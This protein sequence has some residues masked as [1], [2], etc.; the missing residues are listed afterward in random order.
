MADRDP[1]PIM[2]APAVD[3]LLRRA[4][5][6]MNDLGNARRMAVLADGRLLFVP[7]IGR[8]GEWVWFDGRR[9]S[10]RDGKA[11]SR[12]MAQLVVD[13]L[14]GEAK[15]LRTAAA[16]EIA[17][18][19]G[20][21]F[22]ADMADERAVQLFAW[23]MKTGN[24]DRTSGMIR[25]AEGL[26]DEAGAFLMRSSLDAFDTDPLAWHC[27]NG[28][29]RFVERPE[30]W[31]WRFDEGHDPADRF[32]QMANVEYD[33]LADC[34]AWRA[35]IDLLH[36]DPA[37]RT[38]IQRIYGMTLTALTSDQAFYV[39]QGKGG[40]GKSM[41]NSV[42]A[43]LQGDYFRSTSPQ[44]FLEGKQRNASDHQSDIVRLRG[45]I[46]LVVCDEPPKRAT[47]NGERIKQ[48]TGSLITARAPNA[49]EEITFRP[50]WK[51]IVECNTLPRAPSDDRGFRRRFKLYPWTVQFGVSPGADDRPEHIV[52]QELLAEK[53]GILNWMVAGAIE[54]LNAQAIPEPELSRR[55]LSSFW[56]S[57][58]AM[59]E[60]LETRC[61][62]SN[63]DASAGATELYQDFRQFCLDRGDK[64]ESIANQTVF[65]RALTEAQIYVDKDGA[66]RKVRLG[67][68]LRGMGE[69]VLP[70]ASAATP[71]VPSSQA[72][73]APIEAYDDD[74]GLPLP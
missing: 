25:Q 32:M 54:W 45:D 36:R 11:R 51:L 47:W 13:E 16:E 53:A 14:L 73:S 8:Q 69:A 7:E 46:R 55:A 44:T 56:A 9:W 10:P 3:P 74:D 58:S 62:L 17:Q 66:G 23:A 12:S 5:W 42:V 35:R 52:R 27:L 57:G 29:V 48:V 33:E 41:T 21:K 59:G 72:P 38:A 2:A 70:P 15:A 34:P 49:V 50:H 63:P 43:D 61:D 22:T 26:A 37:A 18:V 68:R 24:S 64:E 30:G 40:D 1:G 60:W 71:S 28:T 4:K 20:P 67:I 6:D 19:F 65:G 39:Y 31:D